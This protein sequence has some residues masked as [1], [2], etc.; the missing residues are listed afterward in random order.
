MTETS[1]RLVY[2]APRVLAIAFAAFLGI[3]ALDV[4]SSPGDFRQ[5]TLALFMHLIPTAIVLVIL[6]L[7]WRREWIG[8]ILFPLLGVL[9]LT[10]AWGRFDWSTYF[11]IGGPLIA[12]GALFLINWRNRANLRPSAS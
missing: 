12:L 2:W 3:F 1:K 11:V 4:F 10:S 5:K 8:A 7:A 9:Y 6:A